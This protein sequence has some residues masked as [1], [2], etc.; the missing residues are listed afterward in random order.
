MSNNQFES[1]GDS[2]DPVLNRSNIKTDFE[3][4]CEAIVAIARHYRVDC[5]SERVRIAG[6]WGG[7]SSVEGVVRQ[8]SRQAGLTVKFCPFDESAINSWRLPIVAQMMN[9]QLVVIDSVSKESQLSVTYCG[10]QGLKTNVSLVEL[11]NQTLS[12][13]IFRPR[14]TATDARIDEYIKTGDKHWF[15]RIIL[16][17]LKPYFHVMIATTIANSLALAGIIFSKQVYD[18]VIPAESLPTLYVLFSGVVVAIIFD[19][20]MRT[21]RV[22]VTD[23]LGKRADIRMSDLVFGHAVRVKDQARP[24]STGTF[25]SQIRDL[26]RIRELFTS[27]TVLALADLPFFLLFLFV[28]WWIAGS[29][30]LIP[31]VAVFLLI[32]PGLLLQPRLATLSKESI[33]EGAL[34]NAMLI[35]TIQ[36]LEDI[37]SM[38]AEQRFQGQWN[39]FNAVTAESS[40][41][42]RYLVGVLLSWTHNVQSSVFAV[43]VLFG[44]PMVM[45]GGMTTGALVAASILGS[46]MMAP[47]ANITQIL[48][49]WQQAR[50]AMKGIDQI[51]QLPVDNPEDEKKVQKAVIQ[52]NYH[53]KQTVY[54]YGDNSAEPA[55]SIADLKIKQGERIA[56]LGR[57]GSGKSTFLHA[58]S[59]YI[60]P[61]RG[62]LRLDDVSLAHID[63]ADVRR[64]VSL[65]SQKTGLFHGTIYENLILGAPDASDEEI[66]WALEMSGAKD[67]V[68]KL[69]KGLGCL[70]Q[71]GGH[72]LSGG[73]KQSLLLARLLLRQPNV[74]LLDEPTSAL[75]EATEKQFI[76]ALSEWSADRTVIVATHRTS[77]LHFVDRVLVLDCGRVALDE[78]KDKAISILSRQKGKDTRQGEMV[79]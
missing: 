5:S 53:F 71:E 7:C 4:W 44:A 8:M 48:S 14:R 69:P 18:R 54:N 39:H 29:L 25:I 67:F 38:Q 22:R 57:N 15:R 30:A 31:L 74:L 55:L 51:M 75:D 20:I 37:K 64:D 49:R 66:L 16:R 59:G 65:L 34:R 62:Q 27:S 23:L 11:K 17:D 46:R 60:E 50:F 79:S 70:I 47:M 13:A 26:E 2:I 58:L 56:V 21:M 19:F 42:L 40:L 32:I 6:S 9:G 35:E 77:I 76:R 28:M 36:G 63:P 33:K 3:P 45:G 52:G 73:Q 10:D 61:A 72:G 41:K 12:L 68:S 43:V 24:K 78:P 1:T